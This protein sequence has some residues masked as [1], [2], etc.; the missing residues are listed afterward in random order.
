[1]RVQR[2][3]VLDEED[4]A[5]A[6]HGREIVISCIGP[7]RTRPW[8]PWSPL[9]PPLQVAELT[10]RAAAKVLP[11]A[12]VRRFAAISAAGVGESKV[13]N[14]IM[15]WIIRHSTIGEMYADLHAMEEVLRQNT[16][17]WIAVRPVTLVNA[18]PSRRTRVLRRYRVVSIVGRADVATWLLH[19]A[20][21][22]APVGNRTPMIG[23]W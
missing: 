2:G 7:Q 13:T 22:P 10:A 16:L 14:P 20:T 23:W 19:A 1:V 9:R 8:N 15:R 12:G 17:D 21:D 6:A 5:R 18:R 3:S 11:Q 4:L